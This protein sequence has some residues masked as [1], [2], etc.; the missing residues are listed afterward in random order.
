MISLIVAVDSQYGISKNNKI[1]W[2]IKE[3]MLFFQD[4]TK[5]EYIKN[6]QNVLILGK[7]TWKSLP[8]NF[9][10]LKERINIVISS[11]MTQFELETENITK[12][13][14][15]LVKSLDEAINLCKNL[16]SNIGNIFVIG[17]SNIYKEAIEKNIVDSFYLTEINYDYNC[18]NKITFL[19]D[20]I[21]YYQIHL[22]KQ[23]TLFDKSNNQNISVSFTKLCKNC[24]QILNCEDQLFPEKL[25]ISCEGLI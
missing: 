23:F 14:L 25:E 12:T 2:S 8:N 6:K 17:G 4:I 21:K 20:I 1:P 7:N 15:Y 22:K 9:R 5:K 18:D 3:D 19:K 10:G 11:T 16:E 24:S 13:E